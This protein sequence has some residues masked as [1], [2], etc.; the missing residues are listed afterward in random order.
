MLFGNWYTD[1]MVKTGFFFFASPNSPTGYTITPRRQRML[2]TRMALPSTTTS[3]EGAKLL[4]IDGKE[5][6]GTRGDDD[7]GGAAGPAAQEASAAAGSAAVLDAI[8]GLAETMGGQIEA[9]EKMVTRRFDELERRISAQER[10][11][12]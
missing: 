7:D 11:V 10:R 9:L 1:P 3:Y 4:V 5:V 12:R 6:A 2:P 8:R